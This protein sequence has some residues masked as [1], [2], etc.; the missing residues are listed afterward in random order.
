MTKHRPTSNAGRL[1]ALEG[2]LRPKDKPTIVI[3]PSLDNPG[4]YYVKGKPGDLWP[5][6]DAPDYQTYLNGR[7]EDLVPKQEL[8]DRLEKDY[9][10]IVVT[11][12]KDWHNSDD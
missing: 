9:T 6:L 3:Y 10:V 5:R 8:I 7:P 12:V 2:E 1:N 11:Y 4:L